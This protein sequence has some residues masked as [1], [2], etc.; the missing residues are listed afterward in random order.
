MW[1]PDSLP[2][3]Q[4]KHCAL[5]HPSIHHCWISI[6]AFPAL[7]IQVPGLPPLGSLDCVWVRAKVSH[8]FSHKPSL[9][10]EMLTVEAQLISFRSQYSQGCLVQ[11]SLV[12]EIQS[13]VCQWG[14]QGPQVGNHLLKLNLRES[15]AEAGPELRPTNAQDLGF[16]FFLLLRRKKWEKETE[17]KEMVKQKE[18]LNRRRGGKQKRDQD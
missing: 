13:S 1:I 2:R 12:T 9:L 4:T 6:S 16:F 8:L 14:H 3:S 11:I 10:R 17:S 5:C 7:P 18:L 15:M